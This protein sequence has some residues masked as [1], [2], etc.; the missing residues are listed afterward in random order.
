MNAVTFIFQYQNQYSQT[1]THTI[2]NMDIDSNGEIIIHS[3]SLPNSDEIT[4]KSVHL[5]TD[6]LDALFLNRKEISVCGLLYGLVL[7][8]YIDPSMK[9]YLIDKLKQSNSLLKS[10]VLTILFVEKL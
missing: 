10:Y 3:E 1:T 7:K 6:Q 2:E 9:Y 8:G 5:T 4:S